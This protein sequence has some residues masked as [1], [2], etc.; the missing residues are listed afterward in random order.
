[1]GI[2]SLK[3]FFGKKGRRNG[4]PPKFTSASGKIIR[5]IVIQLKKQKYVENYIK[6]GD[7]KLGLTVT[8]AGRT[9]L[10]KIAPIV[11]KDQ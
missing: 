3:V 9:Q 2:G 1:M 5:D 10:D 11:S 6:E 7:K 4:A 8:K